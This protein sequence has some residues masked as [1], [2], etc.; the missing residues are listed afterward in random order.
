MAGRYAEGTSLQADRTRSEIERT[1]TR[2]GAEAFSYGW[3]AG[4]AIIVFQAEGRRVR[5]DLEMPDVAE[6]SHTPT[7]LRRT[8]SAAQD[9]REKAI[10]QRWRALLLIVKAKLEAVAAGIVTFEEEFLAFVM[11]PD[12]SKV[13]HWIGP[14]L[15][16]VYAT[17]QMPELLPPARAVLVET[18]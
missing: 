12:G 8:Q 11:L 9:A 14:H 1:L 17:G 3:E 16:E 13:S 10:R 5:F 18:T 15:E 4:R 7:G 6:F 2:Y